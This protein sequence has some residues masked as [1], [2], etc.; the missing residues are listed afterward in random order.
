MRVAFENRE[1][2]SDRLF[3]TTSTGAMRADDRKKYHQSNPG[4]NAIKL[5]RRYIALLMLVE[6]SQECPKVAS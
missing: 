1:I 4:R 5:R 2:K 3:D 6:A